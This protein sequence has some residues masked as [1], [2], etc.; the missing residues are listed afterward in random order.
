M[1][2]LFWS[3]VVFVLVLMVDQTE[4]WRRRRRRRRCPVNPCSVSSWGWWSS[5]SRSCGWGRQ[6]RSRTVT[7]DAS[8]G[9]GCPYSLSDSQ[10][11]NRRVCPGKGGL[12]NYTIAFLPWKQYVFFF[13]SWSSEEIWTE[14]LRQTTHTRTSA[15][16]SKR[17]ALGDG[18]GHA[19][20]ASST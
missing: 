2:K 16:S 4:G 10:S 8:C 12:F 18:N 15:Y 1:S 13:F 19:S 14:T 3:F 6:I 11:C 7:A 9:G 20:P 17:V 5:C